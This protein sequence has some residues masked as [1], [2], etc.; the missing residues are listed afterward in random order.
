M[1]E[2]EEIL[3]TEEGYK[4]LEEDLKYLKG[5]KKMEIAE[6]IKTAREFGDIS[7]NSEYDEAKNEQAQLESKIIEIENMLRTAKIVEKISTRT[8]GIGTTV[9]LYDYEFDENVAYHI[10]GATETDSALN[11][12]SKESPVGKAIYGRKKGEEVEVVIPAGVAKYRI[13]EIKKT[14]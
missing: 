14:V 2:R 13:E 8:V 11:K 9:T 12:I 6:K 7:E 10:V 5:T 4:K 3:L 1:G